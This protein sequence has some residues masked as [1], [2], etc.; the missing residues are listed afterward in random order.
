MLFPKC[1]YIIIL[2][3]AALQAANG[4]FFC[5]SAREL[6]APGPRTY[7]SPTEKVGKSVPEPTVLDSLI[8]YGE[9]FVFALIL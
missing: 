5:P 8:Y 2:I 7:F 1:K 3:F 6:S 4:R 9:L